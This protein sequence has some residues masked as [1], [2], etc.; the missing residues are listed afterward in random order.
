M[1]FDTHLHE[2]SHCKSLNWI[3]KSWKGWK[4]LG[5]E[6]STLPWVGDQYSLH[7]QVPHAFQQSMSSEST[8]I[9]LH[10][11]VHFE[12]FMTKWENLGKQ[13]AILRPWMQISLEWATKYYI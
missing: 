9:L 5:C 1:Y 13:H 2:F 11:I 7:W 4:G 8:P 3:G 12:M 6:S 10:A